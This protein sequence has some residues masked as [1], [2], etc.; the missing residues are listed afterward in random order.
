MANLW[1][2]PTSI[3]VNGHVYEIRTDYR[4][5]IDCLT[6]LS[7]REMQGDNEEETKIIQCELIRNIMFVHPDSILREDLQGALNEVVSFIDMYAEKDDSKKNPRIMDWE[8]DAHMI[9][10]AVNRV[11]GHEIRLDQYMHWW[12]FLSAYYEIGDC[13]F[14]QILQIRMKKAKGKKLEKWEQE[15]IRDNS[16]ILLKDK[17]TETEKAERNED[18]KSLQDL[19]G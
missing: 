10:P 9:I 7:D 11:I 16:D 6:A 5:V 14:S 13:S 17:L 8:Q 2:L 19:L 1:E 3:T 12:T 4:V 15:Y 18:L